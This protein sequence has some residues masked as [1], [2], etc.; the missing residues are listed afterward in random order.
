MNKSYF[1]NLLFFFIFVVVSSCGSKINESNLTFPSPLN[2]INKSNEKNNNEKKLKKNTL[3]ELPSITEVKSSIKI[4]RDNPFLPVFKVSERKLNFQLVGLIEAG[5]QKRALINTPFGS[6]VICIGQSGKCNDDG[7]SVL[8][9]NWKVI[10]INNPKNC[11]L[12]EIKDEEKKTVCM[13]KKN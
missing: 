2:S 7:D 8:P 10:Q 13:R 4:G 5:K 11:I 1:K 6:E 9:T 12:I 3:E